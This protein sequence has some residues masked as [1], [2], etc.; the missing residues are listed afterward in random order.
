LVIGGTSAATQLWAGL[1]VLLSQKLNRNPGF[2]NPALY[3]AHKAGAFREITIGN[4][5]AYTAGYGWNPC[6]GHGSPM[7]NALLQAL[8]GVAAP[9]HAQQ[10]RERSHAAVK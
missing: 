2:F 4:N 9:V 3:N 5:G 8:G 6:A 10:Q 1:V 7:G